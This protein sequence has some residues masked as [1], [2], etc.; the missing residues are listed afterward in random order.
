MG[1]HAAAL[2]M[3]HMLNPPTPADG[4]SA[5]YFN[6]DGVLYIKSPSGA[7]REASP[8]PA[9]MHTNANFDSVALSTA[10]AFGSTVP[11]R[12]LP[13]GWQQYWTSGGAPYPLFEADASQSV[14]GFGYSG[15]VTLLAGKSL[16]IDSTVF[17]VLPG[18][19]VEVSTKLRG[20]GPKTNITIMTTKDIT[21]DHFASGLATSAS[22]DVVPGSPWTE[23]AHSMIVPATHNR[24]RFKLRTNSN[25]P[26]SAGSI[27]FDDSTSKVT[28]QSTEVAN[29]VGTADIV[30][31][32]GVATAG[33][34][35][36]LY[37]RNG[38]ATLE[39]YLRAPATPPSTL[40]TVP[41][42][43]RP[44]G[45]IRGHVTQGNGTIRSATLQA[46]GLFFVE[47]GM[48]ANDIVYGHFHYGIAD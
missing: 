41:V 21:P 7:V 35:T 30:W 46:N 44:P 5:L 15:K 24:V 33:D 39:I 9:Q 22:G 19:L 43:F 26:G 12:L 18:S 48:T 42:G 25:T 17:S 40:L 11:E 31:G 27:W 20:N 16:D 6:Q 23:L 34:G 8:T 37:K 3:R 45:T 32:S 29:T 1:L 47:G 4:Q 14:S 10:G 13:T 36:L 2:R 28:A 38:N